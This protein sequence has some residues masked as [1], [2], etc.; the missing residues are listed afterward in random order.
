MHN[1]SLPNHFLL[2]IIRQNLHLRNNY[3]TE[4]DGKELLSGK[5]FGTNKIFQPNNISV[6]YCLVISSHEHSV[7]AAFLFFFFFLKGILTYK[8]VSSTAD[9]YISSSCCSNINTRL[10]N[11][12]FSF[13]PGV[14]RSLDPLYSHKI[15]DVITTGHEISPRTLI[16]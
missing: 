2:V 11:G 14:S 9:D 1:S 3:L 6:P 8:P 16:L 13:N 5:S 4:P 7:H 15:L 10:R 12:R